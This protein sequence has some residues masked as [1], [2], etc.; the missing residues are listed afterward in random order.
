VATA[1]ED[2]LSFRRCNPPQVVCEGHQFAD[3]RFGAA[4]AVL[5]RYEGQRRARFDYVR[6]EASKWGRHLFIA[7]ARNERAA[8]F[9][10]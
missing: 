9:R 2:R 5:H 7:V 4:V 6:R 3:D 8:G 10:S 1:A